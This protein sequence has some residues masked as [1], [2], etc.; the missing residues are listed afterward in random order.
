MWDELRDRYEDD[1]HWRAQVQLAVVL[2]V[3]GV[4]FAYLQGRATTAGRGAPA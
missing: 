1:S 3:I 4:A 2:G